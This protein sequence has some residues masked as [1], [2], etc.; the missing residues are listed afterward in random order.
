MKFKAE[1]L[2]K[3]RYSEMQVDPGEAIGV[4]SAQSVG[5][6]G[7]QLTMR[8]FHFV[9]AELSVTLGLPRII[10][11]LDA[12]KIPSTPTMHIYLKSPYNKN[13][14]KSDQIAQKIK[15]TVLQDIA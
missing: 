9:G 7:T 1:K 6:P 10:E 14:T 5:E 15:Q 2:A 4:I 3:T 8:S 12:R 13:K 11:I